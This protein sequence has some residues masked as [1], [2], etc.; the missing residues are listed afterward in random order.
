[1]KSGLPLHKFTVPLLCLLTS[2]VYRQALITNLRLKSVNVWSGSFRI[3]ALSAPLARPTKTDGDTEWVKPDLSPSAGRLLSAS[4]VSM[5]TTSVS[6]IRSQD[7]NDKKGH[8]V[9]EN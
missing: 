6:G 1:M 9:S 2:Q 7:N 3:L 5:K 8:H 4:D